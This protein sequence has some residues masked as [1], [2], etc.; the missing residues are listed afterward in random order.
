[1]DDNQPVAPP[2]DPDVSS[3]GLQG[4]LPAVDVSFKERPLA[5]IVFAALALL[6]LWATWQIVAPFAA[7]LLMALVI[8]TFSY[9]WYQKL[10]VRMGGRRNLAALVMV[11][12]I[13]LIIVIPSTLLGL[14]L[15]Q[16]ATHLVQTLSVDEIRGYFDPRRLGPVVSL[17]QRFVPGFDPTTVR[18]DEM[19]VG[20]VRQISAWVAMRGSAIFA[21]AAGLFFGFIMMLLASFYLYVEGENLGRQLM[22]LSPL[23]DEY[24]REMFIKFHGVID[25]T[26]RGQILTA[27]AQGLLTG[28]GLAIS[29][30]QGAVFWGTIAALFA[31]IPVAGAFLVWFPAAIY[32]FLKAYNVGGGYGWGI[33]LLIWGVAV[34]SLVDNIIRP[35][36]MRSGLDMNAIVLFFAILGGLIAFG[37]S[38][39]ILGPL[40]FALLVTVLDMYRRFFA[41]TLQHQEVE[42]DR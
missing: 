26:F 33:F 19:L 13:T 41:R 35:W 30:I 28:I 32:L 22:Y 18:V 37:I 15:V 40:V 25:A 42:G 34:V 1:M 21:G 20:A 4:P 16:Q 6:I 38:G 10:T 5:I 14:M 3:P 17:L 31:I 27:L 24:D 11:L 23:P 39:L 8:V 36:A 12:A 7:P 2:R 9:R 29:G